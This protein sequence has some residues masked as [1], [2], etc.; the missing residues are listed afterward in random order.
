MLII[1]LTATNFRNYVDLDWSPHPGC[2]LIVGENGTGKSN[3]LEAITLLATGRSYRGATDRDILHVGS[4]EY[5]LS[6]HLEDERETREVRLL[7]SQREKRRASL[8]SRT[9]TRQSEMVGI[10]R[11]VMFSPEDITISSGEPAIRRRFL[12]LWLGQASGAYL[13]HLSRARE[14]AAQKGAALRAVAKGGLESSSL[15]AWDAELAEAGAHIML[16]RRDALTRLEP[17]AGSLFSELGGTEKLVM[18]YRSAAVL[19]DSS[20]PESIKEALLREMHTKRRMEL[21]FG[22]ALVGPGRDDIY[23]GLGKMDLRRRG[24]RGQ[25]RLAALALKLAVWRLMADDGKQALLL[26]D[27]P[28]SE[29]DEERTLR[30]LD[31][32]SAEGQVIVTGTRSITGWP[33]SRGETWQ[34]SLGSIKHIGNV[35]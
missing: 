33:D 10:L 1:R 5:I 26:L 22:A 14:A 4:S 30:L 35:V 32:I 11:A 20:D 28:L 6:A 25:Q 34:V 17:I 9:L 18:E 21:A 15:E 13:A 27:D 31:G 19:P 2:N 23:I 12:D 8:D 16:W 24:S 3:L 29:L 7:Y